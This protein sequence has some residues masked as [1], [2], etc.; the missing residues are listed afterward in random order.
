MFQKLSEK[1]MFPQ[2]GWA[3]F[4]NQDWEILGVSQTTIKT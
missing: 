3:A 4:G 2:V 1:Y